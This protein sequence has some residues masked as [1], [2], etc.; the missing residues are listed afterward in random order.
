MLEQ[1]TPLLLTCDEAPNIGRTLERLRWARDIVVVDSFSRDDTL[2]IISRFPRARV[3]QRRFDTHRDQWD[4]GLRETGITSEWVL[5]LDADYLLTPQ[6]IEEV[7][8][9]RPEAGVDG[10]RT[11]FV[12]CIQGRPLNGSAYPPVTVLY[13][14]AKAGYRQDGHTQRIQVEGAVRDLQSPILHDDRKSL[15]HWIQ[16]QSRYMRLEAEKLRA[17]EFRGLGWGGRVRKLRVAAPFTMLLYCLF[18]KGAVLNGR[19]GIFYALQRMFS[20]TLLSLYMLEQDLMP[21]VQKNSGSST[22]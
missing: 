19:I 13:R 11:R 6:L 7:E 2:E 16:A 18:I 12:Y 4:F 1:I 10:Y 3:F 20:E 5:A 8:A 15:G 22:T 14:R 21:R 17:A 9:L